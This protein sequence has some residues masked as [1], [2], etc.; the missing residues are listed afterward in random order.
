MGHAATHVRIAMRG[1]VGYFRQLYPDDREFQD[2]ITAEVDPWMAREV[3]APVNDLTRFA[4]S[5]FAR[6]VVNVR[7]GVVEAADEAVR[8]FLGGA[9]RML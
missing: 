3:V 6:S 2:R 7:A 4:S 8:P 9:R 5:L 1:L